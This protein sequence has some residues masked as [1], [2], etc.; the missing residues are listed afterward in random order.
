VRQKVKAEGFVHVAQ[1]TQLEPGNYQIRAVVREKHT[2]Q[3]GSAAQFFQIP[4]IK[5]RKQVSLSSL[6]I[7]PIGQEGFGGH[8]SFKRGS[9]IDIKYVIYNPP[10]DLA[11]LVQR[12]KIMNSRGEVLM[13]APVNVAGPAAGGDA[14]TAPQAMRITLP[15]AAPRGKY[16][17]VVS[18]KDS[19]G[20]FDIER[21]ADFVIE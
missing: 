12:M 4:D 15:T 9:Q 19:K 1:F 8:N 13:D 14:T 17:A 6:I 11:G 5:D 7:T 16:S 20:K 3:V 18:V 2:G 21:A 10:K